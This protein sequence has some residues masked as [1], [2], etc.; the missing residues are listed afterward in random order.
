MLCSWRPLVE[1][2]FPKTVLRFSLKQLKWVVLMSHCRVILVCSARLITQRVIKV[3][4]K[5][6]PVM[7]IRGSSEAQHWKRQ[8]G[9]YV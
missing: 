1:G 4:L 9:V 2:H 7:S 3:V 5:D 8:E 6:E